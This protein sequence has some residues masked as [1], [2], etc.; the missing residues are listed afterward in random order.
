[1]FILEYRMFG[2][3]P[4]GYRIVNLLLHLMCVLV[5]IRLSASIGRRSITVLAGGLLFAIHPGVSWAVEWITARNDVLTCLFSLLAV[6]TAIGLRNGRKKAS[7][8]WLPAVFAFL[9]VASKELGMASFA[10]VPLLYFL[11]PGERRVRRESLILCLSTVLAAALY[12]GIRL[13]VLGGMG[14]YAGPL[15]L[16]GIPGALPVLLLQVTGATFTHFLPLRVFLL[17]V[18]VVVIVMYAWRDPRRWW[19]VLLFLVTLGMFGAQSLIGDQC[20]HYIYVPAAFYIVFLTAFASQI[21]SRS[22]WLKYAGGLFVIIMAPLGTIRTHEEL[23]STY[24]SSIDRK[25]VFLAAESMQEVFH[26]GQ[27]FVL[28]VPPGATTADPREINRLKIYL[29]YF[30]P[31]HG[32]TFEIGGEINDSNKNR[33]FI[34]DGR[35]FTQWPASDSTSAI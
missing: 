9:A 10:A 16:S 5:V 25:H 1:M 8:A 17:A 6:G 32:C 4:L 22:R 12:L 29:S 14:G 26:G 31:G 34:W 19:K 7:P 15:S 21:G 30:R 33:V 18:P 2:S 13:L 20:M 27:T 28:L 3:E 11:W 23:T 35:T 24:T